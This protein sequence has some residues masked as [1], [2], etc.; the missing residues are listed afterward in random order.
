[1]E[2]E[3]HYCCVLCKKRHKPAGRRKVNQVTK[4]IL[5][6]HFCLC[7][8]S[9]SAV[10]CNKCA[11]ICYKK[12]NVNISSSRCSTVTEEEYQPPEKVF[13]PDRS[14]VHSPP[15][16]R[17]A[18]PCT[19]TGHSFCFIC[20]KPGPKLLVTP[21]CIRFRAYILNEVFVPPGSRCCASHIQNGQLSTDAIEKIKAI[22]DSSYLNR[23]SI[24]E[25][26]KQTR[27]E[28]LRRENT[29]LDFDDPASL[30]SHDYYNLTGLE[31]EQFDDL[32]NSVNNIRPTKSRS[33]RTCIAV[34]LTKLRS[35][36]DNQMLA[37]LFNMKKFQVSNLS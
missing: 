29:R 28:V 31:K 24:L 22:K 17:L 37:T 1:M 3:K 10:I 35:G 12:Q 6:K 36:L 30:S 15:S 2:G 8:I 33:I 19:S 23:T 27:D 9:D 21:A 25:L 18:I 20:K 14:L 5:K 7:D 34:L 11:H 32:M 16:I 13:R 4:D 26:L